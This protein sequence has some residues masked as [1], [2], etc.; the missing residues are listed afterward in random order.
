MKKALL[1]A[2]ASFLGGFSYA[3][4][5]VVQEAGPVGTYASIGSAV[6][7]STDGDRIIINN[8]SGG[9]PWNEDILI[10]K[11]LTFLSA[12]DNDKFFVQGE[13]TIQHAPGR[14]IT[15]IGMLNADGDISST[16]PGGTSRTVVNLMWCD[17]N[18][19]E[20][21][22]DHA[23]FELNASGC[24]I[25]ENLRFVYGKVIGN[26]INGSIVFATDALIGED[27]AHVVGNQVGAMVL[28]S[29]AHYFYVSN[30]YVF[31]TN[32]FLDVVDVVACKDGVGTNVLRNNSIRS[33]DD[34]LVVENACTGNMIIYNNIL[35]DNSSG[36]F[37]I[38]NLA[39]T[40][41]T[42][43]ISYNYIDGTFDNGAI[44]GFVN[45]GTNVVAS[46][47]SLNADGSSAWT[48]TIDGGTPALADYDLDLT[49]NDPG[50]FGGSYSHA[51]FFPI[52]GTSSRVYY[53]QMP[54]EILVG[55]SN[56]VTGHS[57]D[58]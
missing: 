15:I 35:M 42:L 4:D 53:L 41:L 49:R 10:N 26:D 8:R 12:A 57:Y 46:S 38:V 50:C 37:G 5:L 3:A 51:N 45:D 54:S 25:S 44:S 47:V 52:D 17:L 16:S 23:Y 21:D 1:F 48:G 14:E 30:N 11:S 6:A 36:D 29:T 2:F 24:V 56:Q 39:G 55:G 9:F 32:T 7:A 34:A 33:N 19:G 18:S 58:R 31:S 28:G 20:V 13:Y 40:A 43:T 22:L 27:S